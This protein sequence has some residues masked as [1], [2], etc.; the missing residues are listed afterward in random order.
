MKVYALMAAVDSG[1]ARV[2]A[3]YAIKSMADDLL[4][5]I[6]SYEIVKPILPK[7]SVGFSL[8][9]YT[10]AKNTWEKDHP[11]PN[12]YADEWYIDEMEL[13]GATPESAIMEMQ[14][15]LIQDN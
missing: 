1:V 10:I 13:I 3:L 2:A 6:E 9:A 4:A 5:N 7:S 12:S 15:L 8:E 14:A 11:F